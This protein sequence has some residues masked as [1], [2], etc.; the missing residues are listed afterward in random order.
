MGGWARPKQCLRSLPSL[1]SVLPPFISLC[2]SMRA[3]RWATKRSLVHSP[4]LLQ[5]RPSSA[6]PPCS[7][8]PAVS[9]QARPPCG[10]VKRSRPCQ[11]QE[12]AAA[13]KPDHQPA[14]LLHSWVPTRIPAACSGVSASWHS[15]R[16][17]EPAG[18]VLQGWLMLLGL[19]WQGREQWTRSSTSLVG[20]ACWG[21]SRSNVPCRLTHWVPLLLLPSLP[22]S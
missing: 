14:A 19:P 5:G 18:K 22:P 6:H 2:P 9:L 15:L 12:P 4:Q 7:A 20:R 8:F 13:A 16:V 1:P 21:W 3:A 11:K 10:R 17:G